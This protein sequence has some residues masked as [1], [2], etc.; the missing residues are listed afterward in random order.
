MIAK[1]NHLILRNIRIILQIAF[2]EK[3]RILFAKTHFSFSDRYRPVKRIWDLIWV[4][5]LKSLTT[6]YYICNSSFRLKSTCNETSQ[7]TVLSLSHSLSQL[8]PSLLHSPPLVTFQ[9]STAQRVDYVGHPG[10]GVNRFA[11]V[12]T[13]V[14]YT[15]TI[16]HR[17]FSLGNQLYNHFIFKYIYA[18]LVPYWVYHICTYCN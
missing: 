13:L 12:C 15:H 6:F 8:T 10:Q 4:L 17:R 7:H 18:N 16:I 5:S 11:H 2:V 1:F 14:Q 3:N 9:R